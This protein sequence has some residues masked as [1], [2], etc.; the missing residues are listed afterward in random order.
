MLEK[1][2]PKA[3]KDESKNGV[4]YPCRNEAERVLKVTDRD[5]PAAIPCQEYV[6][7]I[8]SL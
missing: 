3:K 5:T 2:D 7:H 8:T 4:S 1:F 6:G